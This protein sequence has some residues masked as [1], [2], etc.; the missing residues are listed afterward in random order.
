[1]KGRVLG[2][3]PTQ[4][5]GVI[6][7]EDG[8]RYKFAEEDWQSPEVPAINASVDFEIQDGNAVEI[9]RLGAS[10]SSA[11]A[12][13]TSQVGKKN[14]WVAGLLAIFLGFFGVHKFYLGYI[15]QGMITLIACILIGWTGVG[16]LVLAVIA[17]A[18]GV[19]YMT[20]SDEDF[21]DTYEAHK[22]A[23]F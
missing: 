2:F 17:I 5:T 19:I 3:N 22:K 6:T 20:K 16:A 23:F 10:N 8:R 13:S 15:A 12:L 14:K 21:Y 4:R 11:A 18:E 1:M 7:G 9:Y